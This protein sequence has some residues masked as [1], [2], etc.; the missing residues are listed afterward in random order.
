[1]KKCSSCTKDLPDAALHCVF[2]GAKQAPSPAAQPAMAKT[3]MGY[4]GNEEL[5]RL[6][7]QAAAQNAARSNSPSSPPM[8]SQAPNAAL[9]HAATMASPGPS[10]GM[11]PGPAAGGSFGGAPTAG[12]QARTMFVDSAPPAVGGGPRPQPA[13]MAGPIVP[14][15]MPIGGPSP[16][17]DVKTFA[18]DPNRMAPTPAAG[19]GYNQPAGGGYNQPYT[20]PPVGGYNPNAPTI[21]PPGNA[22]SSGPA[23]YNPQ[24]V[25]QV[26][27]ATPPY[28]APS[29]RPNQAARPIE[30]WKDTLRTMLFIWGGVLVACFAVPISLSPLL[31]YWNFV[32]DGEGTAKLVPLILAAVGILSIVIGAIPMP[33]VPRGA[34]AAV[35]GIAGIFVPMLVVGA[36][37]E[38]Q[39][40]LS[41]GGT[42]LL[43]P[44]LL[45]RNEY[46]ESPLPRILI[47]IGA[48]AAL[49]PFLI[50]QHG[51]I[52]LVE[53][54]KLLIDAPGK[55][56]VGIGMFVAYVLVLVLTLL[57]WMPSPATAGAK[58]LAW[59]LLLFPLIVHGLGIALSGGEGVDFEHAL[60]P[61]ILGWAYGASAGKA[62]AVVGAL[63][64]GSAYV[65]ISAYGLASVIG[66]KLE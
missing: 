34:I 64:L 61:T 16:M 11:R 63:G 5:N 39:S 56:K 47:T 48:L 20:P 8:G 14:G 9:G 45:V 66:K 33:S 31:G 4:G 35:L 58:V 50:P 44:A 12:A 17:A 1:M 40:L 53:L 59:V 52:P 49:A 2:C 29:H 32:I 38:W 6:R 28:M 18:P 54:F 42:L 21:M 62:G 7:D 27:S 65:A 26:P 46:T 3:V 37:P 30:P 36:L 60:N 57:A 19:G 24:P 25:A 51:S 23:G 43:V 22:P 41:I 13:P 15:G 10:P 55:L